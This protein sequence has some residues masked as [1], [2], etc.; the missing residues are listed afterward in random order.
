MVQPIRFKFIKKEDLLQDAEFPCPFCKLSLPK[1]TS[2]SC[3]KMSNRQGH[4]CRVSKIFHLKVECKGNHDGEVDLRKYMSAS[5]KKFKSFFD[6]KFK[7]SNLKVSKMKFEARKQTAIDNGHEPICIDLVHA[8]QKNQRQRKLMVCKT[9]R[10]C[11]NALGKHCKRKCAGAVDLSK[12]TGGIPPG[13]P[14]WR[15][16]KAQK[17]VQH[18]CEKLGIEKKEYQQIQ[19]NCKRWGEFTRPRQYAK[20]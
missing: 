10:K 3:T 18:L 11:M 6:A 7:G 15:W 8:F 13:V 9:C 4:I 19:E 1:F 14:V 20:E 5:R 2:S 16:A 17:K 12:K